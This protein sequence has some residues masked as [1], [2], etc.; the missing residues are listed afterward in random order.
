MP[1]STKSDLRNADKAKLRAD[2]LVMRE[3]GMSYRQIAHAVGLH[4]TR[5]Q[6]IVKKA[7]NSTKNRTNSVG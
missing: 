6:Q 1:A 2:I 5:V 7:S 3:H 4:W